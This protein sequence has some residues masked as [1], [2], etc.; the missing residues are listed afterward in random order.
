MNWISLAD[1]LKE[2]RSVD[3]RGNPK[4]FDL[5]VISLD[6]KKG[7]DGRVLRFKNA[8]VSG[9]KKQLT[10]TNLTLHKEKLDQLTGI[11]K[12]P[13]HAENL[14]LNIFCKEDAQV[15]KIHLFLISRFNGLKVI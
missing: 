1:V 13:S 7:N 5:D 10:Q 14:T 8:I 2:M 4:K 11:K 12:D 9:L 6:K 3:E 15:R